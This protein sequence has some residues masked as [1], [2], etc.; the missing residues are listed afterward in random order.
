MKNAK[1]EYSLVV[2]VLGHVDHGKTT[3]L[4]AIRGTKVVN[5]EAGGITQG[6]GASSIKTSS[7][8][9]I[10]FLDTPGHAAFSSMRSRGAEIADVAI[11]VIAADDGVMPQTKEAISYLLQTKIPFIVALNKIDLPGSNPEKVTSELEKENVLLEG[12]GGDVPVVKVSAKTKE[13][14]GELLEMV[15][16]VWEVND[17]GAKQDELSGYVIETNKDKR[18]LNVSIVVKSG[19]LN[20]G[21]TIFGDENEAKVKAMFDENGKSVKTLSAGSAALVL[22][23]STLPQVGSFVSSKKTMAREASRLDDK[24]ILKKSIDVV[25]KAKT[26]GSLEAI[27]SN[28][29][30][31]VNVVSSGVGDVNDND[32]FLAKPKEATILVFEARVP[33]NVE[34]LASTEGIEIFSFDIIYKLFEKTEELIKGTKEQIKGEAIILD[35]FPFNKKLVA[36]SK[37]K[38]GEISLNDKLVIKR[39]DK[40]MGNVKAI[41]LKKH[42]TDV[43]LVKE[44]EEFGVIFSPQLDFAPG[45]MIVSV[46][47]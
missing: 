2:V 15:E 7:G 38:K 23:F 29:S 6:V 35:T 41:S 1:K 3:L 32:I 17:L 31:E 43:N 30:G 16:L 25:I 24:Q 13:G 10:T 33:S 22:G 40:S 9:Q 20:V 26:A 28:L 14:I 46:A 12:R 36:G 5:K 11:L 47:K 34:K 19:T 37:V 27:L 21:E 39:N 45:D 8:K 4:D 42:R 44:G 18:G